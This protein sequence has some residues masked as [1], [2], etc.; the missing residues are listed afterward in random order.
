MQSVHLTPIDNSFCSWMDEVEKI[1][2]EKTNFHLLDLDDEM[3]MVNFEDGT[4]PQQMANVVI[5]SFDSWVD[6][7]GL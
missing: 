6:S 4:T 7:F 2:L 5:K 1:V 3:Y